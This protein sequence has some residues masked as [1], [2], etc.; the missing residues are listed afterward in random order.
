FEFNVQ[1]DCLAGNCLV[2]DIRVRQERI[3]TDNTQKSISHSAI[4]HFILN[5]HALHNAHLIREVLPRQL[6]AP[7]PYL[8]DRRATHDRFA[9]QLRVSGPAK[10]AAIQAKARATKETNKQ[11][12]TQLASDQANRQREERDDGAGSDSE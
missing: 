3:L 12:K 4:Q 9:E 6:V 1:H 10:R 2:E 5:M 7:I 11:R 8:T